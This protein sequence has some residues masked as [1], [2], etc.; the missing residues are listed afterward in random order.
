MCSR[1]ARNDWMEPGK[2]KGLSFVDLVSVSSS[3]QTCQLELH[4]P[5]STEGLLIFNFSLFL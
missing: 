2:G 1:V 4:D 3:A 5:R